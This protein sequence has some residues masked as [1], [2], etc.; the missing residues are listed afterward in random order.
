[1]QAERT[2]TGLAH[3]SSCMEDTLN[4]MRNCQRKW[5]EYDL[6]FRQLH[7]RKSQS[8]R[9]SSFHFPFLCLDSS[10]LWSVEL[11][12]LPHLYFF[13]S[14]WRLLLRS[15]SFLE[16]CPSACICLTSFGFSCPAVHFAHSLLPKNNFQACIGCWMKNSLNFV[17]L[18]VNATFVKMI[19]EK[20]R[21]SIP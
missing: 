7:L 18:L 19:T 3:W 6:N 4:R 5:K 16:I 12:K 21:R 11:A 13:K 17:L 1:M 8:H 15:S 20:T 10:F 14:I 9:C 2:A